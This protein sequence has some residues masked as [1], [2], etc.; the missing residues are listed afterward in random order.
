M[1]NEKVA[2]EKSK[3]WRNSC[4]SSFMVFY[5]LYESLIVFSPMHS[6][7]SWL[8]PLSFIQRS[9]I[10]EKL[11]L[12]FPLLT[13]CNNIIPM[14]NHLL[15]KGLTKNQMWIR[16]RIAKYKHKNKIKVIPPQLHRYNEPNFYADDHKQSR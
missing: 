5:S 4:S 10:E 2:G 7:K 11:R 9:F 16:R 3:N 14:T 6:K 8:C 1:E 13:L 12:K 15:K